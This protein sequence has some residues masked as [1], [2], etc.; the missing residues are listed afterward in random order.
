M[1]PVPNH[2]APVVA[3]LRVCDA[4]VENGPVG[5][6]PPSAVTAVETARVMQTIHEAPTRN[7]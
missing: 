2:Q 1:I 6:T 4:R 7:E 5:I 3:D